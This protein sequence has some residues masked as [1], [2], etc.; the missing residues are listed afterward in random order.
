MC[1]L[2]VVSLQHLDMKIHRGVPLAA[3]NPTIEPSRRGRGSFRRA[4]AEICYRSV[5]DNGLYSATAPGEQSGMILESFS[6]ST[7]R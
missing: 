6:V 7:L 1:D 5:V 4:N 2:L 3:G